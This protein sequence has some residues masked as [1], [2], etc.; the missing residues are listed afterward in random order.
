MRPS[1]RSSGST[2]RAPCSTS[3]PSKTRWPCASTGTTGATSISTRSCSCP[4][5]RT[6]PSSRSTRRR[7]ARCRS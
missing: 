3:A 2:P 6:P 5:T 7:T 4:C 1:A